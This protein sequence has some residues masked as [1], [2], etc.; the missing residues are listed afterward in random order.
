[1]K[2]LFLVP[3]LGC[4]LGVMAVAQKTEQHQ[5]VQMPPQVPMFTAAE[6]AAKVPAAKPEDVKSM[7]AI[8]AAIYDVISGPAGG[9]DWNRFRSLFLP[10]ARYTQ[11][12]TGPDGS[13]VILTWNVDE[14]VRDAGEI[15]SK[16]PF[17][18]KAIVNRPESFGNVTQ[19]FSS[20]ESRHSPTDKP[21]ERG[22]NSIQ[23]LNDGTRWW[24]LSILWDTERAGNPLPA[25]FRK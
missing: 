14:F 5:S 6:L 22:I 3:V 18:E 1:M 7:D 20:Y 15:F 16:E 24:V 19:V 2:H 9:R 11:V 17:Y 12:S 13:K 8:L 25:K 4:V 21:F 10:Q 23:L